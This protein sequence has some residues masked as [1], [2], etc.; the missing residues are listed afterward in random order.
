MR[1]LYT[2]ACR[3]HASVLHG[4]TSRVASGPY[5]K[6]VVVTEASHHCTAVVIE[7]PS[8]C[9]IV[10]TDVARHRTAGVNIASNL[11]A[12]TTRRLEKSTRPRHPARLRPSRAVT[13]PWTARQ[14]H[15]HRG[16]MARR[17]FQP[18]LR[19][20]RPH[21]SRT[22][23]TASPIPTNFDR[24]VLRRPRPTLARRVYPIGRTAPETAILGPRF[25]KFDQ[26]HVSDINQTSPNSTNHLKMPPRSFRVEQLGSNLATFLNA[27]QSTEKPER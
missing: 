20:S 19:R 26:L 18:P 25:T 7:A 13:A 6:V 21:F 4:S 23:A 1:T 16:F 8:H 24:K 10:K 9:M 17:S 22:R 2:C 12:F 5:H 11:R 15:H 14:A 3:S 27:R